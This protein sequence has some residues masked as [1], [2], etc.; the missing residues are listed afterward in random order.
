V[1]CGV[2][3]LLGKRTGEPASPSPFHSDVFVMH[4]I[5]G[6]P[7]ELSGRIQLEDMLCK[8]DNKSVLDN[9]LQDVFRLI[10]GVEGSKI[11]LEFARALKGGTSGY[12]THFR[13]TVTL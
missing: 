7:A 10:S 4:L 11:T 6:S 8:I 5:P 3:L 13:F 9:S 1:L 12:G 2:G